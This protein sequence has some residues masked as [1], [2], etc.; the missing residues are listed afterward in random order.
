MSSLI[1]R[2]VSKIF[3]AAEKPADLKCEEQKKQELMKQWFIYPASGKEIKIGDFVLPDDESNILVTGS[4]GSGKTNT[5]KHI[6][7]QVR[8]AGQKAI[9]V[10]DAN[11]VLPSQY[12]DGDIV[13]NPFD[14]RFP[15]WDMWAELKAAYGFSSVANA[16]I[17]DDWFAA[18]LL[19]VL[20]KKANNHDELVAL[21]GLLQVSGTAQAEAKHQDLQAEIGV[22]IAKVQAAVN[23]LGHFAPKSSDAPKFSLREWA[24]DANNSRWVF[25]PVRDDQLEILK[26]VLSL[27]LELV[28]NEVI[29]A[30]PQNSLPIEKRQQFWFVQQGYLVSFDGAKRLMAIGRRYGVKTIFEAFQPEWFETEFGKVSR[31]LTVFAVHRMNCHEQAEKMVRV[32]MDDCFG[33]T[34]DT[35]SPEIQTSDLMALSDLTCQVF[36]RGFP[37]SFKEA[38]PFAGK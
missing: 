4:P 18:D 33:L 38:I 24:A 14:T 30:T 1:S 5:I 7:P 3:G 34:G 28:A 21:A 35:S 11:D 29:Q 13:F 8:E 27:A 19:K 6:L 22:A 15:N 10:C 25:L 9:V 12:Q 36:L 16:L 37:H 23:S 20:L 32:L 26:P 17:R 2:A 31:M